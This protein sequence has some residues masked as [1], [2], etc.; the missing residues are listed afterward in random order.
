[1]NRLSRDARALVER[2]RALHEPTPR[3]RQ[4]VRQ[5][6]A[7]QLPAG[8]LATTGLAQT[9]PVA[10]AA[11]SSVAT[12]APLALV[13]KWVVGG[14]LVGS[15]GAGVAHS[16]SPSASTDA[17]R[18]SQTRPARSAGDRPARWT[19]LPRLGAGDVE[20][21]ADAE[22]APAPAPVRAASTPRRVSSSSPAGAQRTIPATGATAA[23]PQTSAA[24]RE[25]PTSSGAPNPHGSQQS[26]ADF[27][28]MEARALRLAQTALSEG[29]ATEALELLE[30]QSRRFPGGALREERAAARLLA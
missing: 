18:P 2:T 5:A 25:S 4:A 20:R 13:A 17:V 22:G 23:F 11:T 7:L 6:L 15:V 10:A 29:R 9:A 24:D 26:D 14:F 28:L 8:A 21:E 27:L 19:E 1:M 16:L 3:E 12:S 30:H